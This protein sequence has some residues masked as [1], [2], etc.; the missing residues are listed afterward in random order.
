MSAT[1]SG[2]DTNTIVAVTERDIRAAC[3]YLFVHSLRDTPGCYHVYGESGA[4]YFVDLRSGMCTCED[5]QY[6]CPDGGCKHRR[7]VEFELG[8]RE[9]PGCIKEHDMDPRLVDALDSVVGEDA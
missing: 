7:R 9:I 5:A 6:R 4:Q 1:T 3:E 2:G 8:E